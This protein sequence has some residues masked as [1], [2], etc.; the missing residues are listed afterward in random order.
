[1][2]FEE[3]NDKGSHTTVF[4]AWNNVS[5]FLHD[6]TTHRQSIW[7]A[8]IKMIPLYHA[9]YISEAGSMR[10]SQWVRREH[11]ADMVS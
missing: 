6:Q 8:R 10:V 2:A 11:E 4:R 9:L 5:K 7:E 3:L 1:M